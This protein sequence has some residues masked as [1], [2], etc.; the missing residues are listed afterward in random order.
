MPRT[1]SATAPSKE[2]SFATR[3]YADLLATTKYLL[4]TEVH[5]FA[6]SVA[7]NAILSF[8]PFVLLLL[9]IIRRVLHSRTFREAEREFPKYEEARRSL[10]RFQ[11]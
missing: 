3:A 10:K 11:F 9:T 7:A 8:F 6:F 5:T 2:T 4:R 1:Q